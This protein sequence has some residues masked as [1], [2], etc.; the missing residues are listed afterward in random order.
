VRPVARLLSSV[1]SLMRYKGPIVDTRW[2]P[3][4]VTVYI[5]GKKITD[6]KAAVQPDTDRS[7]FIDEQ[8]IPMLHD[9]VLQAQSGKIDIISGATYTSEGFILSLQKALKTAHFKA[10]KS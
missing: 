6:V 5:K 10:P 4:Q 7:V 3:V 1:A 2:G 8:S 9:E